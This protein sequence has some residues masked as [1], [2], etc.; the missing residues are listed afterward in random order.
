MATKKCVGCGNTKDV[1]EFSSSQSWK[2]YCK[3]CRSKKRHQNGEYIVE[4]LRKYEYKTGVKTRLSVEQARQMLSRGQCAYCGEHFDA[5]ELTLDHIF[6]IDS[7]FKDSDVGNLTVACRSCNSSKR[8]SH[9]LAF[10]KRSEKFT[11]KL[12]RQF[13]ERYT[14][15]LF[16]GTAT[17]EQIAEVDNFLIETATLYEKGGSLND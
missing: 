3:E 4:R 16:C 5:S 7:P 2:D 13:V 12:Y 10:Q 14:R 6:P 8:N 1:S 9:V 11:D 17:D 15:V